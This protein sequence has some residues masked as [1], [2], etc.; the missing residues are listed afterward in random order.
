MALEI[1]T[2]ISIIVVVAT[3]MA[4]LMRLFKQPT[5]IGFILTGMLVGP[6][7]LDIMVHS[8]ETISVFSKMGIALLLF[9]VGLGMNPRVIKEVGKVS[10]ITGLGQIVFTS[11][12]GFAICIALG[13]PFD[14][15]SGGYDPFVISIYVAIALTFSST[16]IIMKLLSDKH[17][18]QSL[19]GRISVGFLL[20]QDVVAI[21]LLIAVPYLSGGLDAGGLAAENLLFG[22]AIM[23]VAALV[24]IYLVPKMCR[25]FAKSPEFLFFFSIAWG[26]GLASLFLQ[27]G[28]S[29]EIG[30][31]VA[32][33]ALSSSPFHYE[34]SSKMRPLRDFFIMIFFI[35][36]GS[37]MALGHMGMFIIPVILLSAFI[38]IGN[39]LIVVILMGLLGYDRKTGFSAGLTV[40]QISEFSLIFIA[41]GAQQ[42][43]LPPEILSLVTSVGIITI[44]GSTYMIHY[45]ER[46]YPRIARYLGVFEKKGIRKK[47]AWEDTTYDA[48]LFG[49]NRVGHDFLNAFKKHGDRFLAVEC[50]PDIL[51]DLY[52][53]GFN[54]RYGDAADTEFLEDL[55]LENVRIIVSTIPDFDTNVVLLTKVRQ[56]NEDAI[57][58]MVAYRIEDAMRLYDLGASYV[59]MPHFLGGY[60]ASKMTERHGFDKEKFRLEREEHIRYLMRR[61]SAGHEH[62]DTHDMRSQ[63]PGKEN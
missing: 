60:H 28:F 2:E 15:A 43:H 35:L 12:L 31:L 27:L 36:L 22:L 33:I 40:A 48:I 26:M 55:G 44:A 46:I 49:C 54:A 11:L 29:L 51:G 8:T 5:I 23:G 7:S 21:A 56:A 57:V 25:F 4:G 18:L 30:A 14:F 63:Y 3:A 38:L 24:S 59:I 34:I 50:D 10:V 17:A 47:K 45:S 52:K 62:P 16:I 1:F 13:F 61:Q 32:G 20:V 42:G 9:I 41:L 58:L 39:P 6:I 19:Y 53:Q 37:Q